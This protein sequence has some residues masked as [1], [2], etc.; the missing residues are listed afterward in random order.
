MEAGNF[1]QLWVTMASCQRPYY[2]SMH[3]CMH[4][5]TCTIYATYAHMLIEHMQHIHMSNMKMCTHSIC[6]HTHVQVYT[7]HAEHTHGRHICM[8]TQY[9][10]HDMC[11]WTYIFPTFSNHLAALCSSTREAQ[12]LTGSPPPAPEKHLSSF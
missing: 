9:T 1:P 11:I 4:G 6:E 2:R 5:N 8:H 10:Q 3:R 7:M 12:H